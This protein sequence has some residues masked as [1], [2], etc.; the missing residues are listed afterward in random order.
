MPMR[1][2]APCLVHLEAAG[3]ICVTTEEIGGANSNYLTSVNVD[4]H[5]QHQILPT[6]LH[7]AIL[8]DIHGPR[9]SKLALPRVVAHPHRAS[10]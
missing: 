1:I 2:A 7:M 8:V 6:D 5:V 9:A 4:C 3:A 10:K